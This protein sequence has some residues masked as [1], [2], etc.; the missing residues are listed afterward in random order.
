MT[1]IEKI[2]AILDRYKSI[3]AQLWHIGTDFYKSYMRLTNNIKSCNFANVNLPTTLT[4]KKVFGIDEERY[5]ININNKNVTPITKKDK[6]A[7]RS[8]IKQ[9]LQEGS[10]LSFIFYSDEDKIAD[11]LTLD[12]SSSM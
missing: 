6:F 10:S 7:G 4:L 12:I 8:T 11:N 5:T 3:G 2:Q 9:Y 1:L